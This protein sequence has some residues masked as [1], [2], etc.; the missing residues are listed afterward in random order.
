[1]HRMLTIAALVLSFGIP[2][3]E[4][5]S[6]AL[7]VSND[8]YKSLPGLNNART[9]ARGMAAKLSNLLSVIPQDAHA[10]FPFA[11]RL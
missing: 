11:S 8:S 2:S 1:M 6:V 4:R 3:A 10:I 7:A 5:L 9:D